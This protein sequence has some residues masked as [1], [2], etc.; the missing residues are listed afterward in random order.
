MAALFRTTTWA[1]KYVDQSV[2][3]QFGGTWNV[4]NF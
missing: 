3:T 4:D 1:S 2:V